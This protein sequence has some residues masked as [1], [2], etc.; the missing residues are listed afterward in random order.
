MTLFI[1]FLF[2]LVLFTIIVGVPIFISKFSPNLSAN[3][4]SRLSQDLQSYKISKPDKKTKCGFI[5]ECNLKDP[6]DMDKLQICYENKNNEKFQDSVFD[7]SVNS[8]VK[9]NYVVKEMPCELANCIDICGVV[10]EEE[11]ILDD[12]NYMVD[13]SSLHFSCFLICRQWHHKVCPK[14]KTNIIKLTK[15]M[16]DPSSQ[17]LGKPSKNYLM[18]VS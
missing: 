16:I 6:N 2:T 8:A 4:N 17:A 9:D 14:Q 7:F 3:S 18:F 11:K 10:D 15:P 1:P 5:E 13:S 12:K